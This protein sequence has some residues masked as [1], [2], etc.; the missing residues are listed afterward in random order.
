[1]NP[2]LELLRFLTEHGFDER[3][4]ARRLVR[5]RRRPHRRDARD[6]AA[7]RRRR[8]ATAGTLA[9]EELG[10]EPDAFLDAAARGS[11][12]SPAR[13]T[14]CSRPT[15]TTRRSA[16]RSR[17]P[18]RSA[19]LT[20][21]ID[22]Q[23]EQVF[24]DL[25]DDDEALGADR[26]AAARRCAS[27]CA[28]RARRLD[29]AAHPPPRRLPPRPGA[30]GA[31]DDW[32]IIDF[33]G[34]PARSLAERRRKR[35]PLRD[36]AGMLRSFAYAASAA[37]L[38]AASSCR[39]TGS[40]A[41]RERV[42]RRLPRDASTGAAA[43]RP[44]GD[45]RGCSRSSSSRRRSTSCATSSTTAPTGCAI[46]VA[47]IAAPARGGEPRETSVELDARAPTRTRVARRA[48][49]RR[50]RRRARASGPD[51]ERGARVQR[52][53]SRSSSSDATRRGLFEGASPA[54]SCRCATSSRSRYPDG[55]TF[56]L[57]DP[58]S[59]LPTLGELDL[60][61]VGEGRHE[62]LYEQLGAHVRELDGVAGTAFA[63]WAPTA[64]CGLR[65]RRLQLLGRPPAPDALARRVRHLG[66]VRPR[67][68]RRARATSSRSAT[69]DGELRL[70]ADPFAF[71]GR[72]AAGERVGRLHAREHEWRDAEWI[73]RR[74]RRRRRCASRCRSTRCTSA[75]GGATRS[76][77]TA[78]SLPRARRRARRLR[79]RPR[80]H[81]RRADAG[82]GAPV[83]RLVGLP[84]DRLLRAD[85]ALRHARRLPLLR[86][87]PAPA[88]ASA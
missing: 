33:E 72:A 44:D 49:G 29:R 9:L 88:A 3:R 16:R 64:R 73:E 83:R 36:V 81:A 51:A 37:E 57:R 27:G 20:A 68:R 63:V 17:A 35:S 22:E 14:P 24:L 47:G 50:R 59:F 26:A 76:R 42:P 71:R 43:R 46:P 40:S 12:R 4:R 41:A 25:P 87:P 21:T 60:H 67:R 52:A 85:L 58:Y 23:I 70:K 11:A 82:D 13:C 74:A 77:T 80:L 2:E 32:V 55:D 62:Q 15:P 28:A 5:V 86:R 18:S 45:R 30:L 39:T 7:L 53:T 66:A 34:E 61:L 8:R 38:R 84:G 65:R 56:T 31:T 75:R 79:H 78:R 69:P 1:M 6:R 48:P 19:L 10:G 54:R